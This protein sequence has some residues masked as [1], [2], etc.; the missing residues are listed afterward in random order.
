MA[1]RDTGFNVCKNTFVIRAA[2]KLRLIHSFNGLFQS[3][4]FLFTILRKTLKCC[5]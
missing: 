4:L 1:N 2:A 5:T 3:L